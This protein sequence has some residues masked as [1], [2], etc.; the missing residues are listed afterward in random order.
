MIDYLYL[1]I[2]NVGIVLD[3]NILFSELNI[4]ILC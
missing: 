4:E 3:F 1:L 2:N